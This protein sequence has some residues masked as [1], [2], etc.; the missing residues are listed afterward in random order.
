MSSGLDKI[1]SYMSSGDTFLHDAYHVGKRTSLFHRS[2]AYGYREQGPGFNLGIQVKVKVPKIEFNEIK[3][4]PTDP[5]VVVDETLAQVSSESK[6][7]E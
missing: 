7:S 3:K 6:K 4:E 1:D 5:H 2:T